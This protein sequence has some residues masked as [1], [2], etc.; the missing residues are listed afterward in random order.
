MRCW[1]Q[2]PKTLRRNLVLPLNAD[3]TFI[4]SAILTIRD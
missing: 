2:T 1:M 4:P 3:R